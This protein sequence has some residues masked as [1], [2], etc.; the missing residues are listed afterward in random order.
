MLDLNV[1][2]VI[3]A[4]GFGRISEEVLS[5]Y[6]YGRLADVVTGVEFERL[7]SASGPT[8]GKIIRPSDW[9]HPHRPA[10]LQCI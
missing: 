8:M 9:E 10:F 2:A 1:G 4:P 7:T 3:L 6:G 5:K